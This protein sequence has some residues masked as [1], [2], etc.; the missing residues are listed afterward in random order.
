MKTAIK[1]G[2]T[3]T[4]AMVDSSSKRKSVRFSRYSHSRVFRSPYEDISMKSYTKRDYKRFDC[5]RSRDIVKCSRMLAIK[6]GSGHEIT[7]E[8]LIYCTGLETMLSPDLPRRSKKVKDAREM[9]MDIVLS[10]QA[11][12]KLG[13]FNAMDIAHVSKKSSRSAR[14][15]SFKLALAASDCHGKD[16]RSIIVVG[17]V[18]YGGYLYH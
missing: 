6:I 9:H 16:A 10:E 18:D 7:T 1:H 3:S 17:K 13:M 2:G 15:R 4:N 12:K 5:V 14:F 8:D 11:Q